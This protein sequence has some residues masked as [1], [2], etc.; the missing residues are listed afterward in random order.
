MTEPL[1]VIPGDVIAGTITRVR[2][3]GSGSISSPTGQLVVCAY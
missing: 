1:A 3:E 2:E